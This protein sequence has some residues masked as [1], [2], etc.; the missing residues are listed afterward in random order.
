MYPLALSRWILLLVVHLSFLLGV[1]RDADA[2][3]ATGR[4]AF[5]V[6]PMVWGLVTFSGGLPAVFVYWVLHHSTLRRA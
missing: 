6:G 4:G 5:F 3:K 2:Q 1:A